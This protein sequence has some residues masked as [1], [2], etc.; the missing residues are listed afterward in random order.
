MTEAEKLCQISHAENFFHLITHYIHMVCLNGYIHEK[1]GFYFKYLI[2]MIEVFVLNIYY[3]RM[4]AKIVGKL[5][6]S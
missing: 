1:C 4:N 6:S 5:R 3:L 2:V